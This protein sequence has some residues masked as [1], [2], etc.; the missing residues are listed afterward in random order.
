LVKKWLGDNAYQ[1]LWDYLFELK[2]HEQKHHLSA[3]W[4][5][6]RIKRVALSR[7]NLFTE[8][9]GYLEGG[10]NTLLNALEKQILALQGQI[11]LQTHIDHLVVNHNQIQGLVIAG[12][13][14]P[15]DGVI[16][17]IPL[18][19]IP[20]LIPELPSDII[21]KIKAINNF[22]VVCVILK[23]RYSLTENFWLNINDSTMK[24]PG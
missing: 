22:G 12:E 18:P 4:I 8:S 15:Y 24:I 17:T 11:F 5:A 6:T 9:L 16:S 21:N 19:Y 2:F 13:T 3:A 7:N 1:Q 23:L 14:H 20:R 10:S